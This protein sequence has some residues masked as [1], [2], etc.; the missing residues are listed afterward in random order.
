MIVDIAL[1]GIV[2]VAKRLTTMNPPMIMGWNPPLLN[3][4]LPQIHV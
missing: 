4:N 2:S 1:I 3:I